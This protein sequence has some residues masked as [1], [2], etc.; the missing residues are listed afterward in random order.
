MQIAEAALSAGFGGVNS[1]PRSPKSASRRKVVER[2]EEVIRS[3]RFLLNLLA[4]AALPLLYLG[5]SARLWAGF[6][7]LCL[8][9]AIP[10]AA[11]ALAGRRDAGAGPSGSR[12]PLEQE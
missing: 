12:T 1:P 5:A 11:A 7:L 2:Y 6:L 10:Q 3:S 9:L 4:L 8:I